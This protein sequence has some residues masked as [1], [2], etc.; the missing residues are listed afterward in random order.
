MHLDHTLQQV[1]GPKQKT[2]GRH[3]LMKWGVAELSF[4][5]LRK[6]F[7]LWTARAEYQLND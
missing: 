1:Y 2:L 5:L 4:A 3:H 7:Q 6:Q